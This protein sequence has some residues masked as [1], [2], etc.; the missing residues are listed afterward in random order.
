MEFLRFGSSIPGS[1]WGCCAVDIIQDFKQ[2]PSSAASIQLV[3]G[4]GG[5]PVTKGGKMVFAGPTYK[6]IFLQRLRFGTFDNRDMPNHGFLAILTE[7]QISSAIGM[8]W[9]TILKEN[10]F[11]FLRSVSN[12]VYTGSSLSNYSKDR[13]RSRNYIFALFR[14]IGKGGDGDSLTPPSQWTE[15]PYCVPEVYSLVSDE[16][17]KRFYKE[18]HK[19]LTNLWKVDT[20][21][22]LTEEDLLDK[23][24][25]VILAGERSKFP[26]EE[27]SIREK[28]KKV[29]IE[30]ISLKAP[31]APNPFLTKSTSSTLLALSDPA[32]STSYLKTPN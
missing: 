20:P 13:G 14:N 28:K 18:Q 11:E 3:S 21:S 27:K 10:G 24:V 30:D 15:L 23:G 1:Y 22:L 8:K 6:D 17:K 2:D 4:D 29:A 25:P 12:S 31:K 32:V 5:G 16:N 19:I 7:D 9:L 26:Q